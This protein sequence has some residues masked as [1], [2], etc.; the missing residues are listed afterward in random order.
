MIQK[1]LPVALLPGVFQVKD[2][3]IFQS[4]HLEI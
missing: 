1:A 4:E 2:G 3:F